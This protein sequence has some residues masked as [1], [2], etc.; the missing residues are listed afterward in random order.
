MPEN[1][2]SVIH[3]II[4]PVPSPKLERSPA[5]HWRVWL[6]S[7]VGPSAKELMVLFAVQS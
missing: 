5:L 1:I 4:R 2:V 7:T 3:R 6:S